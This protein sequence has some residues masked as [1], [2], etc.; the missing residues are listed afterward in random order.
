[1]RIGQAKRLHR[2]VPQRLEA[3]FRHYLDREAAVEVRCCRFPIMKA[4]FVASEQFGDK[5]FI[6]LARQR[7]VDV[8][9]ACTPGTRFIVARLEP[10]LRQVDAVAMDDRGDGVEESELLFTGQLY[11]R[12]GKIG[13]GQRA[14]CDDDAVPLVRR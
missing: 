10:G 8:I 5:S 2:P 6:L 1:M 11:D 12:S 13:R 4:C 7:A 14:G 3:T 9:S